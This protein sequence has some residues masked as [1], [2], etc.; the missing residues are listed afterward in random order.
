M[1]W[2]RKSAEF[3]YA[4][5]ISEDGRFHVRDMSIKERAWFEENGRSGFWWGVIEITADGEKIIQGNF[6]TAKQA[7][8]FAEKIIEKGC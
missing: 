8:E 4:D 1:K 2:H 7:K 3:Q 6:K 5:Y